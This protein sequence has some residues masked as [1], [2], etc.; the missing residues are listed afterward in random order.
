MNSSV[1]YCWDQRHDEPVDPNGSPHAVIVAWL[2]DGHL[3]QIAVA[4]PTPD[5]DGAVRYEYGIVAL[6]GAV[7]SSV[8]L[9]SGHDGRIDLLRALRD[10]VDILLDLYEQSTSLGRNVDV[11][12]ARHW[13]ELDALHE[14]L[15]NKHL[16]V[17]TVA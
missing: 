11:W 14:R 10:L 5:M 17:K 12:V 8:S 3:V 1:E 2:A 13:D 15:R 7:C 16:R 9:R 4:D 6:S